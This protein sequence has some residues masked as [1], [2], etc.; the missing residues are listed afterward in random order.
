M[1]ILPEPFGSKVNEKLKSM[2]SDPD[3]TRCL[4]DLAI[5]LGHKDFANVRRHLCSGMSGKRTPAFNITKAISEGNWRNI[6]EAII[7]MCINWRRVDPNEPI[8]NMVD[9]ILANAVLICEGGYQYD[10]V[11]NGLVTKKDVGGNCADETVRLGYLNEVIG[12]NGRRIVVKGESQGAEEEAGKS[13]FEKI[14]EWTRE[15]LKSGFLRDTIVA[16]LLQGD[17]LDFFGLFSKEN[18]ERRKIARIQKKM[19]KKYERSS[20]IRPRRR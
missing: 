11:E 20:F 16:D 3:F 4:Q 15:S 1:E 6:S 8:E 5:V 13:I 14:K 9:T 18:R 10:A 12:K 17:G 19:R 2:E 7:A